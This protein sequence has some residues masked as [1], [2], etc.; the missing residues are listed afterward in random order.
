MQEK[1]IWTIKARELRLIKSEI[2]STWD[3]ALFINCT[4][5]GCK[6]PHFIKE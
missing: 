5:N 6:I 3:I 2:F 1:I 4:K